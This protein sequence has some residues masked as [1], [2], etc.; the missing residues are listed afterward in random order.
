MAKRSTSTS[1]D[2]TTDILSKPLT[3]SV[4][5]LTDTERQLVLKSI[6]RKK[7]FGPEQAK[8]DSKDKEIDSLRVLVYRTLI[9]EA[10]IRKRSEYLERRV[11]TLEIENGEL[12]KQL[13][14]EECT[15]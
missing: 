6:P 8:K 14:A 10:K 3:Q 4:D 12:R 5:L 13:G 9:L 11:A 1:E 2:S 15:T 7:L